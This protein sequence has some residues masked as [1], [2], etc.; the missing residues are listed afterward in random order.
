MSTSASIGCMAGRIRQA[1]CPRARRLEVFR[2]WIVQLDEA[3]A[4]LA[5]RYPVHEQESGRPSQCVNDAYRARG[6]AAR[7]R[8][9]KATQNSVTTSLLKSVLHDWP[10]AECS[11][12]L[13]SCRAAMSE[14]ARLFVIERLATLP[15][16]TTSS[17]RA[18]AR[19]DLNML[20]AH[21]ASERTESEFGV[22][23]EKAGF[24]IDAVHPLS[25]GLAA[26]EA[27]PL[28]SPRN[29]D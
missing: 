1:S 28:Q 23:F 4:A 7:L 2:V 20:V 29:A 16:R 17:D 5:E 10:D 15:L 3:K 21:G 26:I 24:F 18:W 12:I 27:H 9:I 25:M 13:A 22:L 11:S 8:D 6:G 14:G 19:S